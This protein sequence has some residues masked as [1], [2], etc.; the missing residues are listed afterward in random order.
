MDTRIKG[1][2]K[3][4]DTYFDLVK[5]FPLLPIRSDREL[6]RALAVMEDLATRKRLDKDEEGYLDVLSDLAEQYEEEHHAIDTD[7][8]SDADMLRH[9]IEA[10]CVTQAEV[11]RA[12]CIAPQTICEILAG[13]RAI[14]R[15][16]IGKL[17]RYFHVDPGVFSFEK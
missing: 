7:A 16:K 1:A 10:K 8:V 17:A 3:P 5:R 13:K 4:R 14:P 12:T 9:L 15:F 11:A 6:A 2:R